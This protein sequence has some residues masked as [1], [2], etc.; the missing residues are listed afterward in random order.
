MKKAENIIGF[1]DGTEKDS[2]KASPEYGLQVAKY[3]AS[4]WF[5]GTVI[6]DGCNYTERR[7]WIEK[8]RNYS[9]GQQGVEFY[10]GLLSRQEE[11]LSYLN[12]DWRP[13]NIAGKYVNL[14]SNGINEKFYRFNVTAVD[15]LSAEAKSKYQKH[16]E[17]EMYS[18][19]LVLDTKKRL[20]ID[21]SSS[22]PTP[23]NVD[24]IEIHMN[25]MYKP[26]Q[27][28]AEELL[29][30]YVFDSNEWYNIKEQAD[31]DLVN[32]GLAVVSCMTDN[33]NGVVLNGVDIEYFIHSSTS[34]NDFSDRLYGGVVK[35]VTVMDLQRLGVFTTKQLREIIYTY[36]KRNSHSFTGQHTSNNIDVSKYLHFKIDVLDFDFKTSKKT[37]HKKR[38]FGNGNFKLVGKT[39]DFEVKETKRYS[40]VEKTLDTWYEGTYVIGSD[41]IYGWKECENIAEDTLNR[42]QGKFICRATNIYKNQLHSFLQDIIPQVDRYLIT[43]LKLQHLIAEIKPGGAE[44][45]LDMV[46]NLTGGDKQD[47]KQ[48]IAI[49]NAKGIVFKK[50]I[51]DEFGMVKEGR[52]VEELH[53]GIPANLIQ[54]LEILNFQKNN[55]REITGINPSRDGTQ[56]HDALVGIQQAQIVAS[57]TITQHIA[58]ASRYLKLKTAEIIS[59][60]ISDIF[61]F[62]EEAGHLIEIYT[63][64]IGKLNIAI[65][66]DIGSVHLHEYGFSMEMLP[67]QEELKEFE[68]SLKIAL[69]AGKID[70]DDI[71]D[72]RAIAKVNPKYASQFLKVRKR[73]RA[74]ERMKQEQMSARIKSDND[75][76][77]NMAASNNRIKEKQSEAMI[78]VESHKAMAMIDIEKQRFLNEVNKPVREEGYNME[79]LKK[80]LEIAGT[81]N[82]NKYKEDKKDD[83]QNKNNTDHSKMIDQRNKDLPPINFN[84]NDDFLSSFM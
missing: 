60:R 40:K 10:Q 48:I 3:I 50:R 55:L 42:A 81:M 69:Q 49:F 38:D 63:K 13:E 15:R 56:A 66:D 8:M 75:I 67:S 77:S 9:R 16:L 6:Q 72:A 59:T 23:K 24:E 34:K 74:E 46:A 54:L 73:Q 43:K 31:K 65:L 51:S 4:E 41:L 22:I 83:R 71:L 62:K 45:D 68:E 37:I 78:D 64:A 79:L 53:N 21:V 5:G 47:Y 25:T 27:E 12:L 76:R 20:G 14:V 35:S 80:Q 84:Q 29:V 82:L 26:K 30:E 11:D 33:T 52:A 1:P 32:C 58:E 36:G 2:V 44:I 57:N 61:R 17:R 7:L 18:R 19:K 39:S 70:E 28:I